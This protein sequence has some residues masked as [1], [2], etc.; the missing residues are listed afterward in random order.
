MALPE[1]TLLDSSRGWTNGDLVT[2]GYLAM[3]PAFQ[4]FWFADGRGEGFWQFAFHLDKLTGV[5]SGPFYRGEGMSQAGNDAEGIFYQSVGNDHY[6]YRTTTAPF[7]RSG[8]ITGAISTE[9]FTPSAIK[10]PPH[11]I[12]WTT[13][14]LANPA[15]ATGLVASSTYHLPPN[16][17]NIGC[18]FGGRVY[19][20]TTENPNQWLASR[21]RDPKD[22]EMSQADVG[23]PVSSQTAKLGEVGDAIVA[24]VPYLD[25]YLFYGCM[26]EVWVMRG[27]PGPGGGAHI[28]NR[29]RKVGFF[30]PE[31]WTFDEK[32]NLFFMS[33]DGI[34]VMSGRTGVEGQAPENL[35]NTRMPGFIKSLGLNRRTDKVEM[36]YDKDRYG[37]NVSITQY[38]GEWGAA[39]FWDL[40]LNAMDPD[41]FATSDHYPSAMYYYDSRK[42]S[43]RGLLMG[44]QDGYIRK[45]DD[46]A[47]DDDGSV[48][49][50]SYCTLG[51][52]Q[53]WPK[54]RRQGQMNEVS[55]RLGDDS[56]GVDVSVYA[57]DAAEGVVKN[58]KNNEIPQATETLT[59]GGRRPVWRPRTMGAV[60]CLQLRNSNASER[61]ALERVTARI[62][63]AGKTKGE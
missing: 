35:T 2:T 1:M 57:G 9:T 50:D 36:A 31:A 40:R 20:N 46:T 52:F 3:I 41:S 43:T 63:D 51:P 38:D 6:I 28:T 27:D 39:F 45:W 21:H 62:S 16:G 29:S 60:Y 19:L 5:A 23:S 30:G 58:I 4:S 26:D 24:M 54:M 12:D 61:F 53:A 44:G 11:W 56:D 22:W 13:R 14:R 15:A 49:I 10:Y 25:H 37:I 32:G 42:A 59:G 34:Y 33:M 55:V 48:A 8:V 7:I 18:L 17:S 47:K